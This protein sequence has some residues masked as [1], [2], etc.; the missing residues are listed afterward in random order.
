[1]EL[2]LNK[3]ENQLEC[4]FEENGVVLS[5]AT[6]GE[7]SLNGIIKSL[8]NEELNNIRIY[9]LSMED[10]GLSNEQILNDFEENFEWIYEL[11]DTLNKK[12]IDKILYIYLIENISNKKG[13]GAKLFKQITKD[14]N[15]VMLMPLSDVIDFWENLGFEELGNNHMVLLKK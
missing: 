10:E 11:R 3:E 6:C 15:C 12:S 2:V 4:K 5:R 9:D 1:M 13:L 14:Y 7:I 8:I